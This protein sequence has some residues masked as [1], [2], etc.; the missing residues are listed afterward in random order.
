MIILK[1][2][3][4]RYGDTIAVQDVNLIIPNESIYGI[5]GRSSGGKSALLRIMSLLEQPDAGEVYYG[6]NGDERVDTLQGESL[7]QKRQKMGIIFKNGSLFGS[8]TAAGNIGYPLEIAG[9]T[10]KE[11]TCR[12]DELLE[13]VHLQDKRNA[14]LAELSS[15]EKQRVAIARALAGELEI[16]FCDEITSLLDPLTARSILGLIRDIHDRFKL[17]VV[18][19]TH[20]IS[21]I[22][23]VC[24]DVMVFD[25]GRI[26]EGGT[27]QTVFTA[28]KTEAARELVYA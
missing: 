16:L 8:R 28:P 6:V 4:K 5:I 27:V 1:G 3:T 7:R 15:G 9:K 22:R 24:D 19:V 23:A 21:V 25:E 2:V 17:T 20:Q 10:K 12:V 18:M 26:V 13:L 14:W 11:R